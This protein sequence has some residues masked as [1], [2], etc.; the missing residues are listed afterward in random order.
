[1]LGYTVALISFDRY[2]VSALAPMAVL[3]VAMLWFAGVPVRFALKRVVV[4]SPFILVLC[5]ASPFYDRSLHDVAL[6]PWRL[7]VSG[8]WLTA[9]NLAAKFALGLLALT[10]LTATTPFPLLLEA[11]RKLGMPRMLVTQLGFVYRYLFVLTDEAMHIRRAR[12]FRGARRAPVGRRLAAVGG[13]VGSLF[14][15]TL[16]RSERIHTAMAA[17]GYRGEFQM[18]A[19]LRLGVADGAFLLAVAAYLAACRGADPMLL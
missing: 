13:I 1:M 18:L 19:A 17:R 5:L 16:D 9:G 12:D 2:A 11:M 15:R 8:G 3:P 4:L 14:V 6:G 10:A 7:V